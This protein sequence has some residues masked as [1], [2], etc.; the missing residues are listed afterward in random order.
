M[1]EL[2]RLGFNCTLCQSDKDL[3]AY[4]GCGV[5]PDLGA[6]SGALPVFDEHGRPLERPVINLWDAQAYIDEH[7]KEHPGT[8]LDPLGAS[9]VYMHAGQCWVHEF[10]GDLW[11]WCPAWFA[12][13]YQGPH[14]AFADHVIS[15]AGLATRGLLAWAVR[16]Q[17]TG[18]EVAGVN[19]VLS[20]RERLKIEG[21]ERAYRE[22]KDKNNQG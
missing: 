4:R 13:F 18:A 14:A 12:R 16:E 5:A 11:P 3:R 17:P 15:L 6:G 21:E 2:D 20:L 22:A 7:H 10:T 1:G 19:I 8:P 9:E